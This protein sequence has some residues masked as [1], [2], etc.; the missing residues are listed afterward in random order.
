MYNVYHEMCDAVDLESICKYHR[1]NVCNAMHG[2]SKALLSV[3]PPV[4]LF[5]KRV[6]CD[7]TK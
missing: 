4:R 7:K 6:H 3:C 2:I 5:V 1:T